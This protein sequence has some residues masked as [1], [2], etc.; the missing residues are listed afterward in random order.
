MNGRKLTLIGLL[1]LAGLALVA[2]LV[3]QPAGATI[4]GDAPPGFG[5]WTINNPTTIIDETVYVWDGNITINSK[6]S[7]QNSTV[8]TLVWA[9]M[10]YYDI[11]VNA[12]G[13]L[14]TNDSHYE[15]WNGMFGFYQ[16]FYIDGSATIENCTID[17]TREFNVTGS[18][19]M[20]NTY[21]T[22]IESPVNLMGDV[23]IN[24]STFYGT[25]QGVF[26]D[27]DNVVIQNSHFTSM[28]NK[29]LYFD[30]CE[31]TLDDVT[32]T[33]TGGS[34]LVTYTTDQVFTGANPYQMA[35][36]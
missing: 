13:S 36:R 34:Y 12:G 2:V 7:V 4:T 30:D 15:G 19:D 24:G 11:R 1:T 9:R 14:Q 18:L 23:M 20:D 21:L 8:N 28:Y 35:S 25:Q 29:G 5:D 26:I 33:V 3:V 27:E 22:Y 31:A 6:L 32:I 17:Y 10:D 16:D